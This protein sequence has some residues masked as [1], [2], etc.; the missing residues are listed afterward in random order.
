M[1]TFEEKLEAI[2]RNKRLNKAMSVAFVKENSAIDQNVKVPMDIIYNIYQNVID[3]LDKDSW[4]YSFCMKGFDIC[5][6]E[7][8]K[9]NNFIMASPHVFSVLKNIEKEIPVSLGINIPE[10]ITVNIGYETDTYMFLWSSVDISWL[11]TLQKTWLSKFLATKSNVNRKVYEGDMYLTRKY[12]NLAK[13]AKN[14]GVDFTLTLE[15][16]RKLLEET[17]CYFSGD[18]MVAFEHDSA[19]VRSGELKLPPKYRTIDRLDN[20]KGYTADNVVACTNE[21]NQI[22]DDMDILDFKKMLIEFKRIR[23]NNY[24]SSQLK[25]LVK[26]LGTIN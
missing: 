22:K 8:A 21:M 2:G 6:S 10:V 23:S 12:S 19:D 18:T 7:K 5:D 1:E 16:L 25:C 15:D 9:G 14:R 24:S 3:L 26:M 4:F 13:S 11:T 20:T 17:E